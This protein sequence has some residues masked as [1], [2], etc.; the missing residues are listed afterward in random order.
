MKLFSKKTI[1]EVLAS[2][3]INLTSGWFGVV[4]ITPGLFGASSL[5]EYLRLLIV[6]LPFGIVGLIISIILSERS[7]LI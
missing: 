6:N 5:N 2:M 4:L 7:K 1:L 3:F